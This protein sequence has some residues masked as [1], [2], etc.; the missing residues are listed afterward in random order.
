[1]GNFVHF[2]V[3]TA[4]HFPAVGLKATLAESFV[5]T[6]FTTHHR[7]TLLGFSEGGLR[8]CDLQNQPIR[9]TGARKSTG[10]P[11]TNLVWIHQTNEI[12]GLLLQIFLIQLGNLPKSVLLHRPGSLQHHQ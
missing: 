9:F 4:L 8:R 10:R 2:N 7:Q 6:A 5:L 3:F 12:A 11:L 1:L